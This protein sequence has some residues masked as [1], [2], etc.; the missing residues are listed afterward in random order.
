MQGGN[1]AHAASDLPTVLIADPDRA[2]QAQLADYLRPRYRV[3]MANSLAETVEQIIRQ[4]PAILLLELDFPD[5]DG[6]KLIQQIRENARTR[7]MVVCCV[8]KRASIHD[9]VSGF[10]SGADD[11]V[12]KPVNAKTFMWRVVLLSRLR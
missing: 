7:Q 12:V 5:G 2:Y 6:N 1:M 9:K 11:Y 3:V 10:Q 4:P 8:T